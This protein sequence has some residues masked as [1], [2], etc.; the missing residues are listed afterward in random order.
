MYIVGTTRHAHSP[1]EG[2]GIDSGQ[3]D[4][5]E[6]GEPTVCVCVCVCVSISQNSP[7]MCQHC[8]IDSCTW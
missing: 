6:I 5:G 2:G 7:C 8:V 4:T 1:Y 3:E